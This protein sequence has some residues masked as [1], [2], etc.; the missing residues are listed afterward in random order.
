[1]TEKLTLPDD[2]LFRHMRAPSTSHRG[3]RLW[4]DAVNSEAVVRPCSQKQELAV[5]L[6]TR[7]EASTV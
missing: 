3:S 6:G 4:Y 1:M 2:A 7:I 5:G